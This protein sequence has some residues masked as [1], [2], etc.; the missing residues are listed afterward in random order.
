MEQKLPPSCSLQLSLPRANTE[1]AQAEFRGFWPPALCVPEL[2]WSAGPPGRLAV[3]R[4]PDQL[5]PQANDSEGKGTEPPAMA[6]RG[7]QGF[8]DP[9]AVLAE[10][11]DGAK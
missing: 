3:T 7:Q 2:C 10:G 11:A 8:G 6:G 5:R 9:W 1:V 4:D